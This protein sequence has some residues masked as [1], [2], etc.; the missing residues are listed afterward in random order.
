[1]NASSHLTKRRELK[2][3]SDCF[4]HCFL[5]WGPG[6]GLRVGS[7]PLRC[8]SLLPFSPPTS[9]SLHFKVFHFFFSRLLFFSIK[10]WSL[11]FPGL[12]WFLLKD[13]HSRNATHIYIHINTFLF[14]CFL[15]P[16]GLCGAIWF[17]YFWHFA[18]QNVQFFK[19]MEMTVNLPPP[20]QLRFSFEFCCLGNEQVSL[21][22][23]LP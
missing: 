20:E 23:H 8:P 7:V 22:T 18:H 14:F 13:S 19:G 16:S 3:K 6:K 10:C 17:N 5:H 2:L 12:L 9:S 1:M 4:L 15:A 21:N 11:D